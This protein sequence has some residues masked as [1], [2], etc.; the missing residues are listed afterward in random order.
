[1]NVR[2]EYGNTILVIACQNGNKRIAKAV[3]RRGADINARNYK[4]NTPLHYCYT[5]GYGNTLGLYL[6]QK[7]ADHSIKNNAGRPVS[8][9]I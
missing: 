6:I 8:E 5:Y 3:L 9:G 4:G 1:M 2:D 7:G